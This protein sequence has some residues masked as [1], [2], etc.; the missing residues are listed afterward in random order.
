MRSG[1]RDALGAELL[2]QV[3]EQAALGAF[4]VLH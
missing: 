3:E 1:G 4:E 2:G